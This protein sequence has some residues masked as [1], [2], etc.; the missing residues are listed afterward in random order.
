[1]FKYCLYKIGLF[2]LHR[3]PSAWFYK[4]AAFIAD[5]QHLFSF[6]DRRAIQ[7]NLKIICPPGA[8]IPFLTREVFRNFGRYLIEFFQMK[9]MA[10]ETFIKNKVKISGI[11]H[12]REALDYGKGGIVLTAHIGNW[13]LGAVLLSV[14]GYPIMAVALPH[15]ERPV[16]DLF[17]AQRESKGVEVIPTNVALRRCIQQLRNN[18]FIAL[19]ADRD[20]G[21]SGVVMDFFGRKA[22]IPKGAALFAIKT[23]APII[24]TFL[25]RNNDGTFDMECR[26][27]IYPPQEDPSMI[28]EESVLK[29]MRQ[30]ISVIESKIREYPEQ[31]LT[32][33]EFC[34]K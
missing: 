5:V 16:N 32:F 4:L 26:E 20:F 34:A 2:F 10:D 18:R 14:M 31:W 27:L 17:N 8:D 1:M 15:K 9:E 25:T 7:N 12:L 3:L 13:E 21:Q 19:V 23:G 33:R 28:K 29:V 11:E 24:P 22:M 30:Y 6:R